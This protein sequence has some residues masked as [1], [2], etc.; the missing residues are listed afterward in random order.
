MVST[1]EA[2]ERYPVPH[3]AAKLMPSAVPQDMLCNQLSENASIGL[4]DAVF[5]IAL[6]RMSPDSALA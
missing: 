1:L 3:S 4:S 5:Q 6:H 2:L